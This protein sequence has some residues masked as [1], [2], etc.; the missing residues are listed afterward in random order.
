MGETG[1]DAFDR[2]LAELSADEAVDERRRS[3]WLTQQASQ[4]ATWSDV[5][6]NLATQER[7]V[8]VE[9]SAGQAHRGTLGAVGADFCALRTRPGDLV[10][11]R[12]A[13]AVAVRP[14]GAAPGAAGE[15][16]LT[17]A[18]RRFVE[19][20]EALAGQGERVLVRC[21]GHSPEWRGELR[22]VGSDVVEL[23]LDN[24]ES[25]YLSLE[26]IVELTLVA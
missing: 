8:L 12:F 2:W 3:A 13:G 21:A 24:G 6:S 4:G 23:R 17:V 16:S 19:A 18:D 10:L 25:A 15:M 20:V 22:S 9:T 14:L 1:P 5:L 11:V 26:A 7:P